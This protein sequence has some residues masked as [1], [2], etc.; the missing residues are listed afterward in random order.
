MHTEITQGAAKRRPFWGGRRRSRL[1]KRRTVNRRACACA[2]RYVRTRG[3]KT[4][5]QPVAQAAARV[6]VPV[7]GGR[8]VVR[9][10]ERDVIAARVGR[11]LLLDAHDG[12]ERC[13][14]VGEHPDEHVVRQVLHLHLPMVYRE[15]K[16]HGVYT[17]VT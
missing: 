11:V 12:R 10:R 17:I 4:L 2:G 1:H 6:Q 9:L 8:V 7:V 14:E 3:E 5:T 13:A 16:I 15:K